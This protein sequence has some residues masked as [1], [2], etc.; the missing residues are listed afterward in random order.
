MTVD[1]PCVE[2]CQIDEKNLY[3]IGC[4]RT[5]EEISAWSSYSDKRKKMILKL[6]SERKK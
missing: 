2:K 4:F 3:C 1:S 6:I 5:I